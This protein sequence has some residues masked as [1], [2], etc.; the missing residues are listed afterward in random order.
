MGL[1][2]MIFQL[3]SC[4]SYEGIVFYGTRFQMIWN[5]IPAYMGQGSSLEITR[6]LTKKLVM[7]VKKVAF[8]GLFVGL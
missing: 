1:C 3:S 8:N 4:Y 7:G 6:R 2:T 5:A